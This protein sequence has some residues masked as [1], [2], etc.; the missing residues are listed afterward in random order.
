LL[1]SKYKPNASSMD[2]HRNNQLKPK[3]PDYKTCLERAMLS[4]QREC[5]SIF[6]STTLNSISSYSGTNKHSILS[7]Q[8]SLNLTNLN[9]TK[10]NSEPSL[11]KNKIFKFD[12]IKKSFKIYYLDRTNLNNKVS[13]VSEHNFTKFTRSTNLNYL[14]KQNNLNQLHPHRQKHEKKSRSKHHHRRGKSKDTELLDP[15]LIPQIIKRN[16]L[17]LHK[18][19]QW[20]LSHSN[21]LQKNSTS[22]INA[23]SSNVVSP[24]SYLTIKQPNTLAIHSKP[25]HKMTIQSK[26][27]SLGNEQPS[28]HIVTSH[29]QPFH[30]NSVVTQ[31][32]NKNEIPMKIMENYV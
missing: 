22:S 17:D 28:S 13:S 1:H 2:Q 6:N 5:L 31:H 8:P 25:S 9:K 18:K 27:N 19:S 30:N 32:K 21:Y 15:K 20:N 16:L 3:L 24:K 4:N 7:N 26:L 23:S 14:N 11:N 10:Y 29:S 12:P